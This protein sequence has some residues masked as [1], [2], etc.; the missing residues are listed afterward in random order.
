MASAYPDEPVDVLSFSYKSAL[1]LAREIEAVR[2]RRGED[3]KYVLSR[4]YEAVATVR[5]RANGAV[6]E[7]PVCVP[8]GFLTD[9]SSVPRWGRWAVSRVGPHLEGSI[10]HD[11][12]YVAWQQEEGMEATEERR[13]FADDIFRQAM[14][15]ANVDVF[16][17]WLI[18]TAVRLGGRDAFSDRNVPLFHDV[19]S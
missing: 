2:G 18:Y 16:Q 15:E 1:H 5:S 9:L 7:I 4:P 19:P 13:R 12:L 3:A 6:F 8:K 11:W 10:I 14:S 17:G